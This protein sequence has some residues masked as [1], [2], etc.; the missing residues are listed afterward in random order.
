MRRDRER[1]QLLVL[2]VRDGGSDSTVPRTT[3]DAL[4]RNIGGTGK[5]I[6]RTKHDIS[7]TDEKDI[8]VL[9]TPNEGFPVYEERFDRKVIYICTKRGYWDLALAHLSI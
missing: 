5:V 2:T 7:R 9:T 3:L 6:S 8:K 4:L 1:Y